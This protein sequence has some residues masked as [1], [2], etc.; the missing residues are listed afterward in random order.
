MDQDQERDAAEEKYNREFCP[1]CG[2]SPCGWDGV[3]D[4]FHTMEVPV[5]IDRRGRL[6][7]FRISLAD[8][9]HRALPGTV[10]RL[11][12]PGVRARQ[13]LLHPEPRTEQEQET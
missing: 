10:L 8:L 7:I 12:P 4:G 13:R 3:P 9:R 6:R 11:A 2:T 5:G 1:A